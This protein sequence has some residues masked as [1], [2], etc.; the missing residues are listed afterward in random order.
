MARE[1]SEPARATL[2]HDPLAPQLR[3][4]ARRLADRW[5]V[6]LVLGLAAVA[7]GT[8]L[9]LDVFTAVATL[10]VLVGFSLLVSGFLDLFAVDRFQPP[11]LGTLSGVVFLASGVVALAWPAA[12]L[13]AVA[14]VAG[15]GLL[16]GGAFRAGA[17]TGRRDSRGWWVS[18]LGGIASCI[19]G[20][21]ALAWPQVTILTLG[22]VLG[23]RTL[24]LGVL[25][26]GF[27]LSLRRLRTERG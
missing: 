21:V 6:F 2:T 18:L 7:L 16:I 23:L 5:W 19:A 14:V 24:V 10:A 15:L 27:A 26:V 13:R 22:V 25:E 11:W 8:L 20:V 9:V 3:H 17:A 12:T 4:D 1:F